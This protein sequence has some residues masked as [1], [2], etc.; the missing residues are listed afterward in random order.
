MQESEVENAIVYCQYTL[1]NLQAVTEFL[2]KHGVA[3]KEIVSATANEHVA[4]VHLRPECVRRLHL[5]DQL[6]SNLGSHYH[7][8]VDGCDVSTIDERRYLV[9]EAGKVG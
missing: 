8:R 5:C 2:E 7:G 3:D 1:R 6:K 9:E 4:S